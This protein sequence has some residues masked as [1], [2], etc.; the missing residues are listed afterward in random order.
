MRHSRHKYRS[1]LDAVGTPL[2][3][4]QKAMRHSD[5]RT[6][7]N[8]YGDARRTTRQQSTAQ[9]T[10]TRTSQGVT[11]CHSTATAIALGHY[12]YP[13]Q[14][15]LPIAVDLQQ[16]FEVFGG[17]HVRQT[18]WRASARYG[19]WRASGLGLGFCCMGT[20]FSFWVGFLDVT[21]PRSEQDSDEPGT[22]QIFSKMFSGHASRSCSSVVKRTAVAAGYNAA[23]IS[24]GWV[25]RWRGS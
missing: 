14:V 16:R 8:I 15:M 4:Q 11:I 19:P 20:G 6:T 18:S 21:W 1:W 7:M 5:I 13:V 23:R 9:S 22:V 3:V 12:L 10:Q 2:A 17:Q 25:T 24:R